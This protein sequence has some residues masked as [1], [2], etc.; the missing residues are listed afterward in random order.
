MIHNDSHD[1][2]RQAS[3]I[4]HELGHSILGHIARPVLDKH[5]CRHFD[6]EQE[7]EANWLGPALLISKEAAFH[8]AKTKMSVVEASR[9]YLVSEQVITMR[10]NMSGARKIFTK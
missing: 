5:G 3:N 1:L 8:I 9:V 6:V 2:L 10:L 4:A 7:D